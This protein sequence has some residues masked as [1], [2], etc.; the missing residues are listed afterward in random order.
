MLD[1]IVRYVGDLKRLSEEIGFLAEELLGGYAIVRIRP[2]LAPLLLSAKE[3]LW[4]EVPSR[5]YSEVT[6]G[7]R[8]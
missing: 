4:T 3:I 7:R 6:N 2:E 1:L 5:V 8:E